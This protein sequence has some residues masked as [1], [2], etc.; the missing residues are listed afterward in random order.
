M[1]WSAPAAGHARRLI[2][3]FWSVQLDG[4]VVAGVVEADVLHHLAQQREIG[5]GLAVRDPVPDHAA[6]DAAE[7]F[8]TGCRRGS[9][10]CRSACRRSD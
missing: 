4:E 7:V 1:E 6:Q 3:Y 8:V 2:F 9:C 10:G 5:R